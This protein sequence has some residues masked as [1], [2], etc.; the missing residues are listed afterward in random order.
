MVEV[1]IA[2]SIVCCLFGAVIKELVTIYQLNRFQIRNVRKH[3][4]S[5]I[6]PDEHHIAVSYNDLDEHDIQREKRNK[7]I[8]FKSTSSSGLDFKILN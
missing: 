1:L 6:Q 8:I 5:Y 4:K 7:T 2:G 3:T